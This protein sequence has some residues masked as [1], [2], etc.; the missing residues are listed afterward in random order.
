M[1]ESYNTPEQLYRLAKSRGMDLVTITDH[2]AIGGV[3][4]IAHREDV[5]VG[6]EI[7][8]EFPEDRAVC[9]IGVL[10]IN[11]EQ[12]RESQ[13]LRGNA[14]ELVRYL[15][16]QDIFC[17]LNHFASLSAGRLSAA[18]IFSLL[19]WLSGLE[20][21]NGTRLHCQNVTAAAVA[22]AEGKAAVGG[23]DSHTYRGI[24]RTYMVCDGVKN[25]EEFMCA[26]KQGR[27]R[28]EGR[29]GGFL[30]LSSDIIRL[31]ARFYQDGIYKLI[32]EPLDWKRQLMV[33]CTTLGLPL[34]SVGVAVAF[35]HCIQDERFNN[36]LLLDL[37]ATPYDRQQ[38]SAPALAF[39]TSG[40]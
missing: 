27:V 13:K 17:T 29:E 1:K 10:G 4:T 24:G 21:K 40:D 3:L 14:H 8:A 37:V 20:V 32:Q 25:R 12:H 2:D 33:L 23:S 36:E 28:A 38:H 35:V 16:D 30:T 31:T 5:I 22:K 34:V 18:Q 39:E 7:T 19:P 11:E 9:H 26:L 15:K 6:C